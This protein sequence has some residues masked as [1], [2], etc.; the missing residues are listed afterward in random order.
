MAQ[1]ALAGRLPSP[2]T[3]EPTRFSSV[4]GRR[5]RRA[6][7]TALMNHEPPFEPDALVRLLTTYRVISTYVINTHDSLQL[8]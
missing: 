6:D 5:T 4:T 7:I 2:T 3:G 8:R 1:L